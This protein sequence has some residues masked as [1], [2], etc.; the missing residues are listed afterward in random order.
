MAVTTEIL[1]QQLELADVLLAGRDQML[2]PQDLPGR[3]GRV[4]KAIDRVLEACDCEAVVVGGWAVWRHGYVGRV[5]QDIDIA[6]AGE[7]V[8]DFLKAASV[9]GFDVLAKREGH[10]PTLH[11]NETGIDVDVLPEGGRPGTEARL[12]PTTIPHP[13][14]MGAVRGRL[15]YIAL[16]SLIEMKLAA[17]R[18]RDDADVLEL[19]RE[20][21]DSIDSIRRHLATVHVQYARRFEEILAQLDEDDNG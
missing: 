16:Q 9:S 21:R 3:Y 4:V 19:V 13:A 5:T 7:R 10:W 2:E 11:H 1:T 12:A 15:H 6:I 20:N 17:G 8:A 14:T 18:L